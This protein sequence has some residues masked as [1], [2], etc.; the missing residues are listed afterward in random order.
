MNHWV[1][2]QTPYLSLNSI[3]SIWL[4][5]LHFDGGPHSPSLLHVICCEVLVKPA[6]QVY[7]SVVP[8]AYDSWSVLTAAL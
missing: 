6:E 8:L 1:N 4:P 2:E 3:V 7:E 5:E